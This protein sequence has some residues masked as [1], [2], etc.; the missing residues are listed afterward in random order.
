MSKLSQTTSVTT[1]T[2]VELSPKLKLLLK[3]KLEE[4]AGLRAE[5]KATKLKEDKIKLEVETL[6][7][8]AGEYNALVAG[9][10]V[11]TSIGPIPLKEV[12]GGTKKTFQKKL[13]LTRHKLTVPQVEALYKTTP[14]ADYLSISL[15]R[16]SG[17]E[18]DDD[19]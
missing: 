2:E 7:S 13:L 16:K 5:K 9:V 6:F 3:A 8:D 14:K 12:I 18:E 11:D 4:F 1:T 19:A 17:E 15:P 10:T